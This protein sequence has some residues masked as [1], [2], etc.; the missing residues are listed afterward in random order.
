MSSRL[1]GRRGDNDGDVRKA[2]ATALGH[3]AEEGYSVVVQA[4]MDTEALI[5]RL[6]EGDNVVLRAAAT[7]LGHAEEEGSTVVIQA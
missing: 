3:A 7:A 1:S 5:G 6:G 4:L 2:A